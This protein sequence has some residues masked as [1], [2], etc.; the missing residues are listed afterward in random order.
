MADWLYAISLL[1]SQYS[2]TMLFILSGLS[3]GHCGRWSP[4]VDIWCSWLKGEYWF[5]VGGLPDN[6]GQWPIWKSQR[7]LFLVCFCFDPIIPL[8]P[9]IF[10]L[11]LF[12]VC[13]PKIYFFCFPLYYSFH[14]FKV[15]RWFFRDDMRSFFGKGIC[16]LIAFYPHMRRDPLEVNLFA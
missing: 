9:S 4:P 14:G 10:S 7:L 2:C 11:L 6:R 15:W 16:S 13:V 12:V 5:S 3:T 8:L 1:A